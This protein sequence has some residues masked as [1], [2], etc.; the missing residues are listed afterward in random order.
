M[1]DGYDGRE[2]R[3]RNLDFMSSEEPLKGFQQK[4]NVVRFLFQIYHS[5]GP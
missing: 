3:S 2:V 1:A 4:G 5:G